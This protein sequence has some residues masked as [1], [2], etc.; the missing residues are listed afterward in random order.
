MLCTTEILPEYQPKGYWAE[1]VECQRYYIKLGT[2]TVCPGYVGSDGKQVWFQVL[3][4]AT[5]RVKPTVTFS[6]GIGLRY[7]TAAHNLDD[8]TL[9]TTIQLN[10]GVVIAINQTETALPP[11]VACNVYIIGSIELLADI[12][13]N[14]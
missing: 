9:A 12:P 14:L 4:P 3:L 8:Y 10:N 1:L 5:M 11:G 2:E 13:E 6:G 7:N